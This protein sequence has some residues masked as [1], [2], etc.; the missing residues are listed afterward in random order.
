M[1]SSSLYGH[2]AELLNVTRESTSPADGIVRRFF[3]ERHYL[4]GRERRWLSSHLYGALRHLRLLEHVV[5][6]ELRAQASGL[7]RAPAIAIGAAYGILVA[8]E[9]PQEV[10]EAVREM[11]GNEIPLCAPEAVLTALPGRAASIGCDPGAPSSLALRYSFPDD[12]VGEWVARLGPGATERLL[13][14]LNEEAPL[15][16]RVNTLKC[17]VDECARRLREGGSEV[18]PGKLSPFALAFPRRLVLDDI[19]AY[20][21]GWF[22]MQDEGSQLL[23]LL[24]QPEPGMTVVDACAGGG[25]KTLH[26]AS[27]LGNRGMLVA[28]DADRRKL[29]N[30]RERA[31]R[32]GATV[33]QTIEARHDD[34]ALKRLHGKADGVL[35]DAPCTGLGTTRRNPWLK[36]QWT[37]E[38]SRQMAVLQHAILEASAPMVKSGGR[39]VYS[40]CT[41]AGAEN[42]EVVQR[43]LQG[44]PEFTLASAS[45]ALEAWGIRTREQ[46]SM[47]SLWP[48][49]TDTDGFFAA[50]LRRE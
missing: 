16:I 19:P 22:E 43:F 35:V 47:L 31:G 24:L 8:G 23:S 17:T 28:I 26:L 32:A 37:T 33:S 38:R 42:E 27:L 41:L 30:L 20:R 46:A 1:K 14:K 45:G 12:I 15:S 13:V 21:D 9:N 6:N 11:W 4:G 2:L 44:H 34:A 48:H 7:D 36:T 29:Q 3:K 5:G 25:G 49:E 39:L 18:L 10:C 50:L 40:T